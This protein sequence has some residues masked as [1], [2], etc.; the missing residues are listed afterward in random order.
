MSA[1]DIK[2]MIISIARDKCLHQFFPRRT[3]S[4][5]GLHRAFRLPDD[6]QPFGFNFLKVAIE[7]HVKMVVP[8]GT[9][10]THALFSH[11]VPKLTIYAIDG[12]TGKG[13]LIAEDV[14]PTEEV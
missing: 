8:I 13:R 3:N 4:K 1:F 11:E 2:E 10:K 14:Y 6:G 12:E 9:I 7:V 5:E